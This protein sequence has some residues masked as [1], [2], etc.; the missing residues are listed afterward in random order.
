M[1]VSAVASAVVVS[2]S[3]TATATAVATTS[4]S[5]LTG[6]DVDECLNL[7]LGSI[8]HTQYLTFEYE[9]HS[10]IGMVEVDG[11]SLLLHV[12][13]E[14]VHALALGIHEGDYITGIDLLVVKFTVNAEDLLVYVEDEVIAT[15]TVG[16]V[17]G[18]GEVE[19][20]ALLQILELGFESFEGEAQSSSELEGM[21]FGSLL[22]E[23]L[24]TFILG[25][26]VVGYDNRL[27][28][29]DF[30]HDFIYYNKFLNPIEVQK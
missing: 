22:Y 7:F 3:V 17:L 10:C 11:H 28:G 19:D 20:V 26:H 16:L 13:Y 15:V 5:A 12:Y 29:I 30:C 8:M 24:H 27:A 14:A 4:A 2:A 9:T 18:E 21:F 1:T 6:D 25:I 23:L